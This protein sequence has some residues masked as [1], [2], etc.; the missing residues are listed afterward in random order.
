MTACI[1]PILCKAVAWASWAACSCCSSSLTRVFQFSRLL[2]KSRTVTRSCRIS[3]CFSAERCFHR[4]RLARSFL[5][6]RAAFPSSF[7]TAP[8]HEN[9]SVAGPDS[10]VK[11]NVRNEHRLDSLGPGWVPGP[12]GPR[13]RRHAGPLAARP[14]VLVACAASVAPL[15]PAVDRRAAQRQPAYAGPRQRSSPGSNRNRGAGNNHFSKSMLGL[16]AR[17]GVHR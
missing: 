17:C 4:S 11:Y 9:P 15:V 6:L 10:G 14:A 16:R 1:H 13:G 8:R 3:C 12:A 7:I 2:D 5:I